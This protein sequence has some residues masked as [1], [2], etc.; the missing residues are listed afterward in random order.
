M[1]IPIDVLFDVLTG[2]LLVSAG[3]L[4]IG[5][6]TEQHQYDIIKADKG[7]YHHAPNLGVGVDN[8]LLDQATMPNL[9]ASIRLELERDG[10]VVDQVDVLLDGSVTVQ[11]YYP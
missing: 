3:D 10:M 8:Y 4:T 7:H 1:T 11:A 6:A 9:D 2:D 5:D